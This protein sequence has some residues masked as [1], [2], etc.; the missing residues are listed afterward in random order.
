MHNDDSIYGLRQVIRHITKGLLFF[1][2]V[3]AGLVLPMAPA[4]AQP[5]E[6]SRVA[7]ALSVEED[8]ESE[9]ELAGMLTEPLII[10]VP[11]K[12]AYAFEVEI[13]ETPETRARGLMF[14]RELH[15]SR[16]M[17]FLFEKESPREFWMKNT[18]LRLD[19]LFIKSDGTIHHIHRNAQP[20]S[21]KNISSHG[22]VKAV[23]EIYGGLSDKMGVE[24]GDIVY[25][26]AFGN[27]PFDM[28]NPVS[29]RSLREGNVKLKELD[30]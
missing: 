18:L 13:A 17:L 20:L 26:K 25:H 29:I 14:R 28:E 23:L 8:G 22:P 16:G 7:S 4:D 6:G 10:D 12:F 30:Q 21:L 9:P 2:F 24:E 5:P 11:G 3:W 19:M 27:D 15:P 1:G